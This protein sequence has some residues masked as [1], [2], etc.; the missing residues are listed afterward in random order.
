MNYCPYILMTILSLPSLVLEWDNIRAV[1][2]SYTAVG[3]RNQLCLYLALK[4][5]WDRLKLTIMA[6]LSIDYH[7]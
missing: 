7:G 3:N 4:T 6:E 2:G 5:L 1:Q